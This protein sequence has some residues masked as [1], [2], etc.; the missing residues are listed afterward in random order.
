MPAWC[1]ASVA[2]LWIHNL[3]HWTRRGAVRAG[4]WQKTAGQALLVLGGLALLILGCAWVLRRRIARAAAR[5]GVAVATDSRERDESAEICRDKDGA[6]EADPE[7]RDYENVPLG[8]DVQAFFDAEVRPHVADAWISEG[9]RDEK[10]GNVGRVGYEINFNRYF[11]EQKPPAALEDIDAAI[12][13]AEKK[14]QE[15]L[16]EVM[17]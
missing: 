17:E 10:D 14:I 12:R 4:G 5:G 6:P 13:E 16:K 15:M 1:A 7:L 8:I 11:Y 3:K 2:S 9:Y